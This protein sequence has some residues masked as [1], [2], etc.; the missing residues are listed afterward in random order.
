M[1][2]TQSMQNII[3]SVTEI[4]IY[5]VLVDEGVK[6]KRSGAN[7]CGRSPFRDDSST[8]SFTISPRLNIFKD[9]ALG[10]GGNSIKF[11]SIKYNVLYVQAGYILAKRY[12]LIDDKEYELAMKSMHRFR[13]IS[14]TLEAKH[15]QKVNEM[16][17]TKAPIEVL[18]K[19]YSLFL[20]FTT[21][22]DA[23]EKHL[24]E[25]RNLSSEE[26]KKMQFFTFPTRAINRKF[27]KAIVSEFGSEDVL[28][29]IPGFYRRVGE[30][31]FTFIGLK[32]IGFPIKN[33]KGQIEAIQVRKDTIKEGE[34]RYIWFSSA[35]AED[36]P[37]NKVELG[38]GSG[39][40][41]DVLFPE[42]LLSKAVFITEG[43]FKGAAINKNYGC[44]AC[45]AQG[46]TCGKR[47][48]DVIKKIDTSSFKENMKPLDT[49]FIAYDADLLYNPGVLK[50]A[51][52]LGLKCIEDGYKTYF[53][54]W[55]PA[56][57]KG[58]DDCIKEGGLIGKVEATLFD[59]V[60]Y[61]YIDY[62][63]KA[64]ELSAETELEM[65]DKFILISKLKKDVLKQYY[66]LL[67]KKLKIKDLLKKET[68]IK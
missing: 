44:I 38:T 32:G 6:L 57:G 20:F 62:I 65:D 28:S 40:P 39:A 58:I 9:W 45:S 4:P 12:G 48:L 67:F 19:V 37:E 16:K 53:V 8:T 18:D 54:L 35:F 50:Q 41:I 14:I 51:V 25:E 52:S 23:H 26:I 56:I 42:K 49:I 15:A 17:R 46:V 22:T 30:Q 27:L 3:D 34:S 31:H 66:P 10:I 5:D 7:Y 47:A 29:S 55:D 33:E 63:I 61:K 21:L 59:D 11:I 2:K 13:E 43:K 24:K 36:D 1:K 60:V 64:E 68:S